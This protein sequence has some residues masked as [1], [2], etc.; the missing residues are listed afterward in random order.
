MEKWSLSEKTLRWF[1]EAV[2]VGD[3]DQ[4]EDFFS[5]GEGGI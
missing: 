1:E 5:V 4:K 2:V 3:F